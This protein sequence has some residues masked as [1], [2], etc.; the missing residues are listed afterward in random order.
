MN[1]ARGQIIVGKAVQTENETTAA[2]E[3]ATK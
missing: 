3:N 2:T 1:A